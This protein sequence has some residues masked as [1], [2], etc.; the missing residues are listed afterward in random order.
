M[1]QSITRTINGGYQ[2]HKTWPIMRARY[3]VL[4]FKMPRAKYKVTYKIARYGNLI[5]IATPGQPVR[6]PNVGSM[7]PLIVVNNRSVCF[8]PSGWD[9]KRLSRSVEVL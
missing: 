5:F 1:Q 4:G 9:M 6:L 3:R 7:T 8:L 2:S